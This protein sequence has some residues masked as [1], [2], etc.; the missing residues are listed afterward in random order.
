MLI[1]SASINSDAGHF[2]IVM[3][4]PVNGVFSVYDTF[5]KLTTDEI[6]LDMSVAIGV[7]N[8]P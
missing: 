5:T 4:P 3:D 7:K 8:K 2:K 1:G 6:V